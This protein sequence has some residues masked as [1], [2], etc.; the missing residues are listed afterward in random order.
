MKVL[1]RVSLDPFTLNSVYQETIAKG[2]SG[3]MPSLRGQDLKK[4]LQENK[5]I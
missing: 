4:G 2:I 1:E 5:A 3:I